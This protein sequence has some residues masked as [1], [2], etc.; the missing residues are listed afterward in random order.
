MKNVLFSSKNPKIFKKRAWG[1]Y[2][3][4]YG[5]PKVLLCGFS[6]ENRQILDFGFLSWSVPVGCKYCP[7]AL[8]RHFGRNNHLGCF[9]ASFRRVP[10]ILYFGHILSQNGLKR[11]QRGTCRNFCCCFEG[12]GHSTDVRTYLILCGSVY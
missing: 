3:H 10:E 7:Q 2:L 5:T 6:G 11:P 9:S 12:P 8:F 4:P 1:E